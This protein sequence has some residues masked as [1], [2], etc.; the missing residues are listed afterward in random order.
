MFAAFAALAIFVACLGLFGLA[1]FTAERRTKEIGIR[2]VFGASVR[3]V[4]KLLIW[5]FSKLVLIANLIAWP[6]AYYYL[7][8]WLDG[9]AYRIDLG[10]WVFVG[11][12]LAALAIACLT[13]GTVAARA[14]AA[15]PV[16]SLRCE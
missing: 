7:R 11:S 13:V 12:G 16:A 9:F 6:V 1:S 8:N 4:V 14:A 5:Q 3:D 10:V 2:K 15:K